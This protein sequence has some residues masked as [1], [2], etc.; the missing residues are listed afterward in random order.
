MYI[1]KLRMV[2]LGLF[3]I[4]AAVQPSH[5]AMTGVSE[6]D[7]GGIIITAA[8]GCAIAATG[9]V[10]ITIFTGGWGAISAPAA[11]KACAAAAV[12]GGSAGTIADPERK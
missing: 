2:I 1:K 4:S 12:I 9:S 11:G 10:L 7:A 6:N 3:M 5:A 8:I